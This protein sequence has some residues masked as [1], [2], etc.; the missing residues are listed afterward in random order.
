[1]T[2]EE[3]KKITELEYKAKQ[4]RAAGIDP[5]I[6]DGTAWAMTNTR[7]CRMVT[8]GQRFWEHPRL[9]LEFDLFAGEIVTRR[10][11]LRNIPRL[12][13]ASIVASKIRNCVVGAGLPQYFKIYETVIFDHT[14]RDAQGRTWREVIRGDYREYQQ[15]QEATAK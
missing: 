4:C 10:Y 3:Y 6:D 8:D 13:R 11:Y 5:E 15:E 14:R 2:N 9:I 7:E 12:P 1:M